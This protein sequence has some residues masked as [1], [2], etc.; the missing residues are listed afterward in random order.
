MTSE[1]PVSEMTQAASSDFD[2]FVMPASYAQQRIWFLEQWH[3]GT[4]TFHIPAFFR[5]NGPLNV[6]ALRQSLTTLITRHEA[7]RTTF[8]VEDGQ[9]LQ[10]VSEAV[11]EAAGLLPVV[12]LRGLSGDEQETAVTDHQDE[13]SLTPFDLAAGP[14]WRFRLLQ[15]KLDENMLLLTFHHIIADGWSMDIFCQEL[16]QAYAAFAAEQEPNFPELPLQYADYAIWQQEQLENPTFAS[17]LAYWRQKLAGTLPP[18]D[19]P[20]DFARPNV[21]S[22][23]S[24]RNAI[25]IPTKISAQL[26]Q[27]SQ[28]QQVSPFMILLAVFKLWLHRQ[29]NQDDLIVGAPIAGRN[30]QGI[31]RT[32]GCFLNTLALRTQLPTEAM[33]F[34]DLLAQVRQAALDAYDNQDVPFELLLAEL[35]PER[36]TSRTPVFQVMFNMLT[37]GELSLSLPNIT[38][39]MLPLPEIGS[40]FDLTFYVETLAD[41]LRLTAVYNKALFTGARIQ[42]MLAQYQYLLEQVLA[43][44]SLSLWDYSLVTPETVDL[45]PNPQAELPVEWHGS[46]LAQI[47]T[48]SR[49]FSGKAAVVDAYDRTSYQQLMASVNQLAHQLISDGLQAEDVVAIYGHRSASLLWAI[50]GILRAGSAFVVLDPAYPPQRLLRYLDIANIK[51]W[52]QLEAAGQPDEQLLTYLADLN[53]RSKITLPTHPASPNSPLAHHPPTDPQISFA[54]DALAYLAFTSGTTGQPKAIMGTKRPLS[55]FI[56]WY[57][58]RFGLQSNDHFSLLSGLAHDPLL[59]DIF[60]PLVLGATLHIPN[61]EQMMPGELAHWLVQEGITVT[62][63]TPAMSQMIATGVGG[64]LQLPALRYAIFGGET[65]THQHVASIQRLAPAATCVNFYG[66]T[67]TP[68]AM[69]HHVIPLASLQ[70]EIESKT[71]PLGRGIDDVQLLLVNR[72]GRL[73]GIGELAEIYVRTRYLARGYVGLV[74]NGRFQPNPLHQ[75]ADERVYRTGDLA[76]Y[77]P[78]GTVTFVGREDRQIKIRGF[79]IELSEIE[80][81]LSAHPRIHQAYVHLHTN[82]VTNDGQLIAYVTAPDETS[83]QTADIRTYLGHHLPQYMVPAAIIPLPVLPLTANGKLDTAALPHPKEAQNNLP[84]NDPPNSE[85]EKELVQVWQK[86]LGVNLLGVHQNFFELGGHS[87]LAIKLF[88]H[89]EK[90]FDV[91]LPIG[92]IFQLPTVAQLAERIDQDEKPETLQTLVAMQPKGEAQPLFFVHGGAG[93]IFLFDKLAAQFSPNRPF[94]AFQPNDWEGR[95][96]NPPEIATMA[97]DYLAEMRYVQP[98]GPYVIGGFCFGGS[99]VMEMARQLEAMGETVHEVLLIEPGPPALHNAPSFTAYEAPISQML[100]AN[101]TLSYSLRARLGRLKWAMKRPFIK[102]RNDAKGWRRSWQVT[103]VNLLLTLNQPIPV[104]WR[105]TYF[106]HFVSRK[107]WDNYGAVAIN[108]RVRLFLHHNRTPDDPRWRWLQ[109]AHQD[110]A[111]HT[112]PTDHFGILQ[113]PHV[114]TVFQIIQE[115]TFK[116][117]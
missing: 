85:T 3:P 41:S 15:L 51:G 60:T 46:L 113:P 20:T 77:L 110:S 55:H 96:L 49:Q 71:I 99:I 22:S 97:A 80:Q 89:I 100:S 33:C 73:A 2:I 115:A 70:N 57:T 27:F 14:L 23:A 30:Q 8:L 18:L 104:R 65:L 90:R 12:D 48:R 82:E 112:L 6:V 37:E 31:E 50:L 56:H 102:L 75:T 4:A 26:R 43:N 111:Y 79:R 54:P 81:Q 66:A 67:E 19:L 11:P 32:F 61:L 58:N 68:Q 74:D 35:Q 116:Q 105:D 36:D 109:L 72:N 42:T 44:P 28:Q 76:R 84:T 69:G 24:Q 101:D 39:Q 25:H 117:G 40:K 59:R 92:T 5:L 10:Q 62:H 87:L 21:Q 103:A 107:S 45:L 114:E 13:I 95:H 16:S 91:R 53:L 78:D 1:L 29:T 86:V 38:T 63:L 17:Q 108:G 106:L 94:Y 34:T 93:H 64:S 9:P 47:A 52:I 98:T 83:I 7:L 88:A